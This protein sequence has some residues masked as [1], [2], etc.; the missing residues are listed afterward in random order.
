MIRRSFPFPGGGGGALSVRVRFDPL[1]K[2]TASPTAS[3]NIT[4]TAVIE[5]GTPPYSSAWT[6][7]SGSTGIASAGAATSCFFSAS[8][9]TTRPTSSHSAVFELEVTDAASATA[10]VTF[11]VNFFFGLAEP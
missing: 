10:S 6:R 1:Q 9:S 5:G 2:Y 4:Q 7:V 8:G 11:T 3:A